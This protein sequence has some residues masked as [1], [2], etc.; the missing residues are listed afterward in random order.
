MGG[1]GPV[2]AEKSSAAASEVAMSATLTGA[3][4]S[5]RSFSVQ[6]MVPQPGSGMV[7]VPWSSTVPMVE[8]P[9]LAMGSPSE[10]PVRWI[11]VL[12]CSHSF[13]GV[14]RESV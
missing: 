2:G 7:T 10:D 12:M 9:M 6:L 14:V 4:N 5:V 8:M 1:T 11:E 13:S 3:P